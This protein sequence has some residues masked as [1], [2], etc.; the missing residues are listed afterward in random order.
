MPKHDS[1]F[2]VVRTITLAYMRDPRVRGI[3]AGTY[4]GEREY[5]ENDQ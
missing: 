5:Q 3:I 4:Y 2:S 1:G